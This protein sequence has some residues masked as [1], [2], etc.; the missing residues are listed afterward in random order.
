MLNKK[1]KDFLELMIVG[2]MF[3]MFVCLYY[4]FITA[5]INP[6]KMVKVYINVVGEANTEIVIFSFFLILFFGYLVYK[7][8]LMLKRL[9]NE[10]D[11]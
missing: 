3:G 6:S 7:L 8:M 9:K 10:I 2:Q 1:F 4:V 11:C 5:Y